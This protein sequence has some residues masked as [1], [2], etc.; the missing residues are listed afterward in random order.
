MVNRKTGNKAVPPARTARGAAA[1]AHSATPAVKKKVVPRPAAQKSAAR[2][3]ATPTKAMPAK[4]APAKATPA[5]AAP[6]K[7]TPTKA[8]PTKAAPT[9]ATPTKATPTKAAPVKATPKPSPAATRLPAPPARVAVA[10]RDDDA[11][12]RIQVLEQEREELQNL[13]NQMR[14]ELGSALAEA[15]RLREHLREQMRDLEST[16]RRQA[17]A[18]PGPASPG[19]FDPAA[20]LDE[21]IP[22]VPDDDLDETAGFFDRMDEIRARRN[23]LDRERNDRELEQSDQPFWMICPK[24]GDL[25]EESE[26][27]NVKLERCENCGGLYL[28]RGEVDLIL[29]LCVGPDAYRRL[30]NIMKF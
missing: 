17:A 1:R 7:A 11:R 15:E 20:D 30:H 29:S 12:R 9:K 3:K 26:G 8:T 5:K 4:T 10:S 18:A 25:M 21:D 24:C 27:E 22:T 6:T 23:E 28:D 16:Q 13:G 2:I 19:G 14:A